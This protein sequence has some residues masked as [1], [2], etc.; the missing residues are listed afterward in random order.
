MTYVLWYGSR[1]L[2]LSIHHLKSQQM[3]QENPNDYLFQMPCQ[4]WS[5]CSPSIVNIK[6][7][8]TDFYF[9]LG[10]YCPTKQVCS[11]SG[12]PNPWLQRCTRNHNYTICIFIFLVTLFKMS[13]H[14]PRQFLVQDFS[15]NDKEPRLPKPVEYEPEAS[16]GF[17]FGKVPSEGNQQKKSRAEI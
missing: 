5:H 13:A 6:M 14:D 9:L 4:V 3:F 10:N 7:M 2:S 17:P 16:S 1:H 15:G 8:T 12:W 11:R